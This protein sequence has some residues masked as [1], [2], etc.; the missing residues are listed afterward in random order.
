MKSDI[1]GCSTCPRGQ[2][3]FEEFINAQDEY[4]VQYDYRHVNGRLFTAIAP[5]LETARARRDVWLEQFA[6]VQQ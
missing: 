2:E 4:R 1:N 3:Q 5:D 6:A